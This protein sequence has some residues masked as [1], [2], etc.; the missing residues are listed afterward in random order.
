MINYISGTIKLK[1][2]N[3]I[4]LENQGI[5]YRVFV[6]AEILNK[7]KLNEPFELYTYQHV[8]E[9]ALQLFG[10]NRYDE[11]RLFEQLISVSGV[12]PKT[13][14]GIFNVAGANDIISAIVS[15]DASV[16][17]K[18]SGIGAKT[19]ERIVLELKNKVMPG[20][21]IGEMKSV[22]ELG[23]DSDAVEALVSLGYSVNQGREALKKVEPE[24]KDAGQRVK[25]ALK[26]INSKF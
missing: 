23:V 10:F 3:F 18:V 25:A 2:E 17:K 7:V 26:I 16:L 12:G 11:L 22:D 4:I 24:I 9:D 15:A 13:A 5:G 6:S 14:L 19:A 21:G 1:A 8:R 20:V